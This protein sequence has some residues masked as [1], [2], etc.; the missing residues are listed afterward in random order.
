[1]KVKSLLIIIAA[2]ATLAIGDFLFNYEYASKL[3]KCQALK[4]G[5]SQS[6]LDALFGTPLNYNPGWLSY[7]LGGV[8]SGP[9]MAR[10]DSKGTVLE[11]RCRTGDLNSSSNWKID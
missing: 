3:R 8:S 5:I 7:K 10:I 1:M 6:D 4:P 2:I 9:I 11:L